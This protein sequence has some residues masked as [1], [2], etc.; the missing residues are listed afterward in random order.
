MVRGDSIIRELRAIE[1]S[2]RENS[3]ELTLDQWLRRPAHMRIFDDLA[4]VTAT[5]Q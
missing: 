4:R 3:R 2:Y 5:V 1:Q